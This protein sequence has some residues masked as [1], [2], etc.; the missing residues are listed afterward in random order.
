MRTIKQLTAIVPVALMLTGI[1]AAQTT[2]PA[3]GAPQA[4]V[5]VG[6]QAPPAQEGPA[7]TAPVFWVSSVEVFHSTHAPQ[8]DIVRVRGLTSTEGWESG[9]LVPLTKGTP[10]DGVLDLAF[11]ATAPEDNTAPSAYPVIEAVFA[12]EPGHPFKGVR[13]HGAANGISLANFPGY[14]E[15]DGRPR[16]CTGCI[17][18][19]LLR[20][21]GALP[22][23]Q[24]QSSVVREEELPKNVRILR[25]SE[26][27]GSL[28]SDPNRMTLVVN[29]K[30]EIVIALWD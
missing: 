18:K 17:G 11:V 4:N 22:A 16:D 24:T 8:L 15:A 28:D 21:G 25:D 9:E 14:A 13:V 5:P 7:H 29:E 23:N 30:G 10:A 20:K 2:P 27:I 19:Y 3:A 1:G 12:I 6:Q 26:G